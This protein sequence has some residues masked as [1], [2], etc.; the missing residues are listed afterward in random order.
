MEKVYLNSSEELL[1]ISR[2]NGKLKKET[3]KLPV[4]KLQFLKFGDTLLDKIWLD[5]NLF[6]C[7]YEIGKL[8]GCNFTEPE[9]ARDSGLQLGAVNHS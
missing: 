3:K 7:N 5:L 8:R 2:I 4:N 9:T 6:I 1:E